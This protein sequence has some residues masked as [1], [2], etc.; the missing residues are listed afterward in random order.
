MLAQYLYKTLNQLQ[1]TNGHPAVKLYHDTEFKECHEQ[2][3]IVNFN[4][5]NS[6][7]SFVGFAEVSALF[8][9]LKVSK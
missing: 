8:E 4:V 1:H 7:G 2:G 3:A 5:L 9:F 6:D